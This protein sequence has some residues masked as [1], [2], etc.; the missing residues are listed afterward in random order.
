MMLKVDGITQ[1]KQL[2]QLDGLNINYAGL[3]F[4]EGSIH[5][6]GHK[7]KRKDLVSSDFDI[8]KVGVFVD[9]SYEFIID[10]VEQYGLDLVQLHGNET[11]ELCE[12]LMDEVEVIKSFHVSADQTGTL[13][14][15]LSDYD[16]VCDYYLFDSAED[17]GD[18]HFNWDVLTKSKIEKPFFISGGIDFNDAVTLNNFKH[19]DFIGADINTC[20]E[21]EPGVKDLV[22]VL[23]FKKALKK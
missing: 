17:E 3:H 2:Q 8:K 23:Q 9:A 13:D 20:F 1:L 12:Q 18:G 7:I 14:E 11:P 10:I 15:M 22:K 6:A 19:P 4:H 16:E 21:T 5:Y